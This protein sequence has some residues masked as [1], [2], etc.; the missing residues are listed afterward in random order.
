M[1]VCFRFICWLPLKG[2]KQP[3]LNPFPC[4]MM[5]STSGLRC[6]WI[7]TLPTLFE[8]QCNCIT[9]ASM[10]LCHCCYTY[11]CRSIFL[12]LLN[13]P[14]QHI[15]YVPACVNQSINKPLICF[16]TSLLHLATLLLSLLWMLH[17]KFFLTPWSLVYCFN[18]SNILIYLL[19]ASIKRVVLCA[20][21]GAGC[22]YF[23]MNT[24]VKPYD[25]KAN[26]CKLS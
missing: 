18:C 7:I 14:L 20:K 26:T 5:L 19:N 21:C 17:C 6:I 10:H 8:L 11:S 13:V 3:S 15:L 23:F 12:Q 2:I 16:S 24:H 4:T 9:S 22:I 25:C 1:N